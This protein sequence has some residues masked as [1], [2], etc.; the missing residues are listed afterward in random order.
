MSF[1]KAGL[2]GIVVIVVFTYLGFNKFALPFQH[3]FTVHAVFQSAN[4]LRPDSLVRIAGVNVGKV[5]NISLVDKNQKGVDGGQAADVSMQ[6]EDA[7]LPIHRDATF[8]IRPRIFLEGNFFVDVSPGSP[9]ARNVSDGYTFPVQ[10]SSV[11]VQL[12]QVLGVLKGDTRLNLQILL[13]EYGSAI[14]QAA[15]SYNASIQ[16]WLPAYKYSAVVSHDLLGTKPHDL[17]NYIGQMAVVSAALNAHP[18]NLQ[19]LITDFNTTAN[20][21]ARQ[22]VALENT[23]AELPVTLAAAT[24]ALNSLNAAFPPLRAFAR[25]LDPGVR[26]SGPAIDASLPFITQLQLLVRPQELQGLTADLAVTV[27]A[28]AN[29]TQETIPFMRNG[30]RPAS[31]CVQNIVLPWSR[32]TI[33]DPHFNSSNGFPPRPVS[34]EAVDF[35]PGLAGETRDFDANGPFI[36]VGAGGGAAGPYSLNP[37]MVGQALAPFT[38]VQ[39]T[40]PPGGKRP[41]LNSSTPCET[42]APITSVN[43]PVGAA[44]TVVGPAGIGLPFGLPLGLPLKISKSAATASTSQSTA[45]AT[46]T[47]SSV[48]G[49]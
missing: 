42:Q 36:R 46:K 22:N 43:T 1:F 18:Q 12:D 35:L 11:P 17:S 29:L 21:F 49:R 30:V 39:P 20:A 33:N 13:K 5:T 31:S 9:S 26:S 6:I 37:G 44:P 48:S 4:G 34:V 40:L 25:T 19:S 8:A 16:Y 45:T 23:V 3:H 15:P 47:T 27:P 28:L 24:P 14:A 41:P 38:G 10:A 7:G 32:L 2:I